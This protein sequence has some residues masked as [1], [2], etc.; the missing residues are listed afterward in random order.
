M[1]FVEKKQEKSANY[2]K[3]DLFVAIVEV[4]VSA[5]YIFCQN[6][7]Q[8]SPTQPCSFNNLWTYTELF[9]S[10]L[11]TKRFVFEFFFYFFIFLQNMF[12][13]NQRSLSLWSYSAAAGTNHFP[14]I[15]WCT[16]LTQMSDI[17]KQLGSLRRIN[18]LLTWFSS[19]Y[20]NT[21]VISMLN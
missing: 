3:P 1:R 21:C 17:G 8:K 2:A 10:E 16:L 12:S 13:L 18:Q 19:Y 15:F 20:E 4:Q 6:P 7:F 9:L 11:R 5:I 14:I